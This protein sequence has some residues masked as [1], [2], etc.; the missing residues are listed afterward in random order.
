MI[1]VLE[2]VEYRQPEI[3]ARIKLIGQPSRKFA[4]GAV[5]DMGY[6]DLERLMQERPQPGRAGD[7]DV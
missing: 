4:G 1:T 7:A 6:D 2:L 5:Y 3:A